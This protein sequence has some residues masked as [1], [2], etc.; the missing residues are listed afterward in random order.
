MSAISTI[1]RD[2]PEI[3]SVMNLRN[4][5]PDAQLSLLQWKVLSLLQGNQALTALRIELGG[6]VLPR[7]LDLSL[8]DP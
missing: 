2:Q 7:F 1:N 3:F 6:V 5:V 8:Y 4:P